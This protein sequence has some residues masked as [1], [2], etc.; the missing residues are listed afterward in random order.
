MN[1][2]LGYLREKIHFFLQ[3]DYLYECEFYL[4][5]LYVNVNVNDECFKDSL[6]VVCD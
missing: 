1:D 6:S 4:P 3:E 5:P 2:F